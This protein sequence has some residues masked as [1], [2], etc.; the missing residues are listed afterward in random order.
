MVHWISG[1]LIEGEEAS[2]GVSPFIYEPYKIT[3]YIMNEDIDRT[4]HL[5]NKLQEQLHGMVQGEEYLKVLYQ[6]RSLMED[7]DRM[8]LPDKRRQ[9]IYAKVY[10][11]IFDDD[12][13]LSQYDRVC[14]AI[15]GEEYAELP[16]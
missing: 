15:C 2:V 4:L 7:F 12:S 14:A 16:F 8:L 5:I 9:G 10:Q 6:I 11:E 13:G 3:Q 1:L